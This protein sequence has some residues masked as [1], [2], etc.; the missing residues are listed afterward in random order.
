MTGRWQPFEWRNRTA[1]AWVPDPLSERQLDFSTATVRAAEQATAA[2]AATDAALPTN[3]EPLARLLLRTE[4]IASSSIEGVRAP[5]AVV[6]AAELAGADNDADWIAANL[7]TVATAMAHDGPLTIEML[8]AWH[9]ELMGHSQL[10]DDMIGAFRTAPGWIGGTSPLDAAFV[11]A[12][13]ALVAH[14]VDRL[15]A[16]AN[17][18]HFDP[19]TQAALVHAQFETIHPY[20]DGNGRLGRILIGWLLRR[21]GVVQ[22][23]APPISVLIARDPGG[24]ISGLHL[25]RED[26]PEAWVRWFAGICEA[27]ARHST[28]MI[29][30]VT[31]LLDEWTSEV[32]DLRVD[33]AARRLVGLLPQVPVV[34]APVAAELLDV[35]TVAARVALA[36]LADRGIVEAIT[37]QLERGSGRPP[38]YY[39][40]T[41]LLDATT[42]W[43]G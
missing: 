33:A 26:S 34:T 15:V 22:R 37:L 32:A 21:R 14:L 7:A 13:A 9:T 2:L 5:V 41:R 17:A 29:T 4:G 11:P 3:W 27:A 20:G 16:Y 19:V 35:S 36:L 28:T 23:L 39:A 30:S 6:A 38:T 8:H 12:P 31:A 18:D 24:Y 43:A 10:P 40:A 25:F 1:R 42:G